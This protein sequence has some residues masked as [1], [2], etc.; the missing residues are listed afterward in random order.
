MI[1][2]NLSLTFKNLKI[3]ERKKTRR[4]TTNIGNVV[5]DD[6]CLYLIRIE[7]SIEKETFS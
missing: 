7:F 6:I 5:D 2:M 3:S 4:V 1:Q